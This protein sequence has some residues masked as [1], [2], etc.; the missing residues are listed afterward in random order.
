MEPGEKTEGQRVFGVSL[1]GAAA[2]R[3]D[4]VQRAGGPH[5]L[6]ALSYPVE[7]KEPGLVTVTITPIEGEA[8][9]S[10]AVLEPES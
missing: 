8:V 6:L 2:E 3:I 4:L 7:L 9:I 1:N 10:G 5:R